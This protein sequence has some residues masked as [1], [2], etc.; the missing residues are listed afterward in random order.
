MPKITDYSLAHFWNSEKFLRQCQLQRIFCT[1]ADVRRVALQNTCSKQFYGK[2]PGR[3]ASALKKDSTSDV[4]KSCWKVSKKIGTAYE[5]SNVFYNIFYADV[6]TLTK[7][8][9]SKRHIKIHGPQPS[10]PSYFV[11]KINPSGV[12]IRPPFKKFMILI[13]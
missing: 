2:L 1:E 10:R 8:Y 11:H 6:E 5:N 7:S 3:S 12:K 13:S 4:F 9:Y